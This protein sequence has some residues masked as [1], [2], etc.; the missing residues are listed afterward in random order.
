VD[1]LL[2]NIDEARAFTGLQDPFDQIAALRGRGARTVIVTNGDAGSCAGDG[3]GCWQAD[4]CRCDAIDPSGSGDA[5]AAGVIA[6]IMRG[7]N[8]PQMLRF[9]SVLGASAARALGTTA[10][11]FRAEEADAF[12]AAHPVT[13]RE[14]AWN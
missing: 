2:P 14:I 4:A 13:V 11:V 12:L 5:F 6:G 8:V 7:W 10:G 1:Y 9:G 3:A